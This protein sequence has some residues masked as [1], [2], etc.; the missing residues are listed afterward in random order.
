MIQYN[1]ELL[2]AQNNYVRQ[3][4]INTLIYL[5]FNLF[6]FQTLE[7]KGISTNSC[8][9]TSELSFKDRR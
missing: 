1:N 9:L 6:L 3:A 5:F 7:H 4:V 2:R 8:P